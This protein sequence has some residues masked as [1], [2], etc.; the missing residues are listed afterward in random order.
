MMEHDIGIDF[1]DKL[2]RA[3]VTQRNGSVA[4][5]FDGFNSRD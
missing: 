1:A 2:I 4:P 5:V 3:E